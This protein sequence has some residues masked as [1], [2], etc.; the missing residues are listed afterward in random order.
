MS[1]SSKEV[2]ITVGYS[3]G[4]RFDTF[5]RILGHH[6]PNEIVGNV[7]VSVS[8]IAGDGTL[9]AVR[10]VTEKDYCDNQVD[11]VVMSSGLIQQ[12]ILRGVEGFDAAKDLIY[13]GAS[14]YIASGPTWCIRT[15]AADSLDAYFAGSYTLGQI[16]RDD[17]YGITSEWAVQV[18]FPFN[19]KFDYKDTSDLDAAFNRREIDLIPTCSD[20]HAAPNP[21]WTEGFATPLFY[22]TVEPEWVKAGKAEGKWGWVAPLSEIA[23][24][25]LD[26]SEA[27]LD[28]LN[29]L[30]NV[31][32]AYRISAMPAQTPPEV[33][34]EMR[35]AFKRVV[36]SEEFVADMRSRGYDVGLQQG[37]K[38]QTQVEEFA[39]LPEET[40][41]I[42][43][44][45][46]PQG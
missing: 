21:H 12:S 37:A 20:S 3:P 46:F 1:S 8:N 30:L 19:R 32:S 4:D 43:R 17:I 9:R 35:A 18:G 23:E 16:G 36:L 26:A 45:L 2:Q 25:R 10:S 31:A 24:K 41:N 15:E 34:N 33:V 42:I 6:L 27:Y 5:A 22:K 13:L 28:A 39:G 11:I 29:A 14:D 38:Y 7:R 44:G 40:L